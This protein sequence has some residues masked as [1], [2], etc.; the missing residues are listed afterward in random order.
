MCLCDCQGEAWAG[1]GL[2][3]E[4]H[5]GGGT[6]PRGPNPGPETETQ[7]GCG[8]AQWAAGAGQEGRVHPNCIITV[9]LLISGIV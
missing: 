9:K 7:P 2:A 4:S 5:G 1:G 3:E 8:G 6:E